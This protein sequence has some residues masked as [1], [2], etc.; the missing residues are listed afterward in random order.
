MSLA[1]TV[2]ALLLP[3]SLGTL[4]WQCL[5]GR[6]R[7]AAG[8]AASLGAGYVL[9]MLLVGLG[10]AAWPGLSP[11]RAFSSF[12]LVV[13]IVVVA[14][15]A[16]WF[17]RRAYPM[18][19]PIAV[20]HERP[21][22]WM[23]AVFVGL[24]ALLAIEF[25][26]IAMQASALPSLTWDAWNAWL[27]KSKAWYFADRFLPVLGFDAWLAAP[28]GEAITTTAPAY[29]GTLPRAMTWM[30]SASGGWNEAAIH[31]MWPALWLALGAALFGYSRL[32]G[33]G[34]LH[35]LA[36]AAA[37]LTLPLVTAHASLAGYADLWLAAVVLFAGVHLVRAFT[38]WRAASDAPRAWW[39]DAAMAAIWLL[40][41]PAVK[42]E[43][44]V[45]LACA[46]AAIAIAWLPA[47]WRWPAVGALVLVWAIG[48]PF[49]GWPL[50]LPGVGTLRWGW[51]QM[52]VGVYGTMALTWRPVADEVL[53]SL[54][55]LPNWNLLWY[56]APLVLLSRWRAIAGS[57][58]AVLGWWL[59]FGY[60]FLFLLFFFTDA[61]AWA[62]N[63]TSL[64]RVLMQIV[65][66]TV[67]W[68]SVLWARGP[69]P[70]TTPASAG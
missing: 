57:Q 34:K 69:R 3:A 2:M 13:G 39:R 66:L 30:A 23:R 8:W 54:Y 56:V 12:A 47:R 44:V 64:N 15:G 5:L 7:D 29:P 46:L 51:G 55:L 26:V 28:A 62:E 37:V 14:L 19:A 10:M 35:S 33:L 25:F 49:G 59:L 11:Q 36:T 1:G 58:L 18:A 63:L 9:G 67:F 24:L 65:P 53:Q 61:S 42:L 27:A 31:A 20:E 22:P 45:W 38:Q 52:Q 41:L 70:N 68:L 50:P 32:A 16:L 21:L 43:G 48:L 40:L 17:V 6:P 4:A 60:A